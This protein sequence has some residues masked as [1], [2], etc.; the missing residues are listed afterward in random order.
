[1]SIRRIS[2]KALFIGLV[3]PRPHDD[4]VDED[5]FVGWQLKAIF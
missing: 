2:K 3:L 5:I 1:M 4:D